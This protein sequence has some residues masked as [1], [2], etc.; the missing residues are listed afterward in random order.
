MLNFEIF[1][2]S[3]LWND[4]SKQQ[5]KPRNIPLT[6]PEVIQELALGIV[7]TNFEGQIERSARGHDPKILIEHDKRFSNRVDD[8]ARKFP[9]VLDLGELFTKHGDNP[10]RRESTELSVF[11]EP[12]RSRR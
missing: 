4:F 8:R 3:L 7:G 5:T 9:G 10:R 11:G 2:D 12:N 1:H 6:V